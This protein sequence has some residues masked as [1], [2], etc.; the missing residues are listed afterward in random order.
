TITY[1]SDIGCLE[2]QGASLFSISKPYFSKRGT[3]FPATVI[4]PDLSIYVADEARL[5]WHMPLTGIVI[6]SL[7]MVIV[8]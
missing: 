4:C 7:P 6:S 3:L 2:I 5:N 8:L 1:L